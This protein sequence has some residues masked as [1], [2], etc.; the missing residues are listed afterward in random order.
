MSG[1]K[2]LAA[3]LVAAACLIAICSSAPRAATDSQQAIERA[4][5]AAESWLKLVD[6]G[7]YKH[8]WNDAAGYFKD[9]VPE[10]TWAAQAA[11]VRKPLGPV[12]SRTL[13]RAQYATT[14]PGAPDGQYVVIQYDSSFQNKK[15]AVETITPM[16][17]SDGKWHVS[18]Y[19]IR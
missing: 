11:A 18:G 6:G 13:K 8:S 19:Y 17:D 7:E 14:L 5:K 10:Q 2:V 16:L 1:Q 9:R 12:L 15:S 3:T 4:S